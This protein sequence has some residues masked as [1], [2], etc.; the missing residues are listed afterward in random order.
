MA[1]RSALGMLLANNSLIALAPNGFARREILFGDR[2]DESVPPDTVA[3]VTDGYDADR[4][5]AQGALPWRY[6]MIGTPI[7]LRSRRVLEDMPALAGLLSP[8]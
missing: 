3:F 8:E 4:L 1:A 5:R 7:H 2:D 6:R